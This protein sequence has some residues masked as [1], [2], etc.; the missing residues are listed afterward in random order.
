MSDILV[1]NMPAEL[2]RQIEE[3]ARSHKHSLSREIT[4]LLQRALA[5]T[6]PLESSELQGGLGSELARIFPKELR[7]EDF[8]LPTRDDPERPPP[9]FD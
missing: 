4:A 1:R 5:E 8:I 9:T 2:K 7:S 3:R 6:K